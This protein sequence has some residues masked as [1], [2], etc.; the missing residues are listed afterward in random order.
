M[1]LVQAAHGTALPGAVAFKLYDTYGF[2]CDLTRTIVEEKGLTLDD[3]G[4][5]CEMEKQRSLSE[6]FA[7][8]GEKAVADVYKAL[9]EELGAI[10][11]LGYETRGGGRQV[12]ALL[13]EHG[14][15][16]KVR[17]AGSGSS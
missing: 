17:G 2:P 11:F 6:N 15:R 9:R 1:R 7:G 12:L 3:T 14:R 8:S 4:F 10:Q 13:D 5:E 16:A